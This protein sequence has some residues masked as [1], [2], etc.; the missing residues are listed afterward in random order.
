MLVPKGLNNSLRKEKQVECLGLL[1]ATL[2]YSK[3]DTPTLF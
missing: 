3:K 1:V 2:E